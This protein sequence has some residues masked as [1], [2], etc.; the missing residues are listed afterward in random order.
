[1]VLSIM[2]SIYDKCFERINQTIA[3]TTNEKEEEEKIK[4]LKLK[5]KKKDL[6]N[7]IQFFYLILNLKHF[8]LTKFCLKIF[9]KYI[10]WIDFEF[11]LNKEFL[12]LIYNLIKIKEFKNESLICLNQ[13]LKRGMFPL[14]KLNLFN[15]IQIF[16]FLNSLNFESS[17][18]NDI[19]LD[20]EYFLNISNLISTIGIELLEL[21]KEVITISLLFIHSNY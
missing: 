8:K 16:N 21:N 3:I 6:K 11:I 5:L 14:D 1:M 9:S 12:N 18:S 10:S 20:F 17:S 2:D 15:F 13:I 7:L 19:L 4:K